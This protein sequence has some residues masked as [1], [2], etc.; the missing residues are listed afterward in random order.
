MIVYLDEAISEFSFFKQMIH[1]LL[2]VRIFLGLEGVQFDRV[3]TFF[4]LEISTLVD[5]AEASLFEFPS[6]Y[7]TI[8]NGL[9]D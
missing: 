5:H 8:V 2:N 7:P 3:L 6:D 1:V 4:I 9:L